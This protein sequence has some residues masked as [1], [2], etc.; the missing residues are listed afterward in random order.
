MP[1][2]IGVPR[3][4]LPGEKRV[5]TVPEVVERLI[6]LGFR[7][8]VETNAGAQANFSDDDP[9]FR[10]RMRP[11]IGRFLEGRMIGPCVPFVGQRSSASAMDD[12]AEKR[13]VTTE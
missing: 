9:A 5:A 8:V 11:V 1:Q 12:R 2:V 4:T 3:E 6:K 7:V 13:A 10:H